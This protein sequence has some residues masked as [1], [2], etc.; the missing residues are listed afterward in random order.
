[1]TV[2][3][4][5][6]G[7][8]RIGRNVVRALYENDY[9]DLVEIV[10]I[11]DVVGDA[12][13]HLHL[14]QYDSVHGR[15]AE[16]VSHNETHF[17]IRHDQIPI[18]GEA[19]VS[20]LPWSDLD[21]DMVFECSG[22]FT[23]STRA[24][25]HLQAGSPKVLIS[26]P[27]KG[28]DA[29]IVFGVNHHQ[30]TQQH[31]LVSNASCTTNCLAPVVQVLDQAF[32]IDSGLMTTIHS[33]TNDQSLQDTQHPDPYRA[34][35]ATHSMIPTRTGAASAIGLVLPQLAG[36][37]EG[38]A[39]RVPTAN[40]SLL[41]LSLMMKSTIDVDK[42]NRKMQKAA[43][44]SKIIEYIDKPL[45]SIDF[46]HHPAS[47]IFDS[48]QTRVQQGK[49]LKV[50]AWYDNEWGFSNRMLDTAIAWMSARK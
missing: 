37:L 30:L 2:R 41:D 17:N 6:N 33:Y 22:H 44:R 23:D 24:S 47:A 35:S 27:A 42:V 11:N 20:R 14:L 38:M 39:V 31:Q 25:G 10:A 46:N 7:F 15:F 4:A 3:I 48:A 21:V 9:R 49:H 28:V 13:S 16:A 50:M 5:I 40:V 29:T 1:M 32:G 36:R 45:V 26:A 12:S 8:G 18:Y 43:A 19:D 34:R